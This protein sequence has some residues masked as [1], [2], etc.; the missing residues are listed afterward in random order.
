MDGWMVV[1]FLV[2]C[3]VGI[4]AAVGAQEVFDR[5]IERRLVWTNRGRAYKL[6]PIEPTKTNSSDSKGT[7]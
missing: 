2:G 7:D 1:S 5:D 3:I 4:F 6:T